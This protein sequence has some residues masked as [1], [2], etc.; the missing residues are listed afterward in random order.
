MNFA[1]LNS[2]LKMF[3]Y[4]ATVDKKRR[5][6]PVSERKS[7]DKQ[8]DIQNRRKLQA[9]LRDNR[10]NQTLLRWMIDQTLDF[11][12]KFHFQALT[13]NEELNKRIEELV[14]WKSRAG[15][16]E[17]TGRYSRDAYIRMAEACQLIDGDI[18]HILVNGGKLQ[19]IESDRI[20][21]PTSGTLPESYKD[22]NWIHGIHVSSDGRPLHY[23][24]CDRELSGGRNA[25]GG[26]NLIY[27]RVIPAR[28]FKLTGYFDR[29][30]QIRG[31][32]PLASAANH[33]TDCY[34]A[35]EYQLQK[36]K[37]HSM[38]GFFFKRE[39][40]TQ[41]DGFGP[42]T[43]AVD[44]EDAD[45]D[46]ERYR[47]NMKPGLKIEGDPGDQL[48]LIESHTPSEE[49][50]QFMELHIRIALLAL[51]IPY[52][53]Y[54]SQ[55]ATYSSQRMDL[56]RYIESI[57]SRQDRWIEFLSQIIAWDLGR[58]TIPTKG[59][60]GTVNKPILSLPNKMTARDIKFEWIPQPIPWID[61]LKEVQADGM[62]VAYGFK[63]RSDVTKRIAGKRFEDVAKILGIEEKQAIE[64]S[65]TIAIGQPGQLSTRD[66]E[67]TGDNQN[68]DSE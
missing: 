2:V 33:L 36:V 56:V 5:S 27:A 41:G 22:W 8:L 53:F 28:N 29:F 25:A 23:C 14:N 10:R 17:V 57:R 59:R 67:D 65:A 68:A 21:L 12:T 24:I 50:M 61:P 64:S 34:E 39:P 4:H 44:G 6:S 9:T 43:D 7:E 30:D 46:T 48:D 60:S 40:G 3:G 18:G 38:L 19:G 16:W 32:S 58:W 55:N 47:F 66:E 35:F 45:A 62:A 51:G 20:T 49:F 37:N 31:I 1:P 52:T 42:Y 13:D 15:N 26:S 54:D 11:T 63:T